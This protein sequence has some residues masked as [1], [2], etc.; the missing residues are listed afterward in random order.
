[1]PIKWDKV[2]AVGSLV[3]IPIAVLATGLAIFVQVTT[4]E[5]R[6]RFG[7]EKSGCPGV[8]QQPTIAPS[9]SPTRNKPEPP[10]FPKLK[11][12]ISGEWAGT[13]VCSQGVI[14]VTVYIEQT[15]STVVAD[16]RL[17]PPSENSD[18]PSEEKRYEGSD[19]RAIYKGDFNSIS[20]YMRFPQ[21]EWSKSPGFL[22]KAFGFQ[23]QFDENLETFSGNMDHSGCKTFNL[24]RKNS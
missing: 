22:W 13:Y 23:G 20:R 19:G 10:Q 3:A 17:Y 16:L 18:I 21:G 11:P 24:K 1:M 15:G 9:P 5:L 12:P 6:C 4:P 14:G 2:G 7:L 8:M